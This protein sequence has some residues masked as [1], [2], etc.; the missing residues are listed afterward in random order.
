MKY[1]GNTNRPTT[2]LHILVRHISV[3][4]KRFDLTGPP[5]TMDLRLQTIG[6]PRQS[7]PG[8]DSELEQPPYTDISYCYFV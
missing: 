8:T 5:A 4:K 3:A 2:A 7:V 1:A 6:N